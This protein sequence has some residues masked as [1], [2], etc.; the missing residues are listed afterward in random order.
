MEEWKEGESTPLKYLIL[1]QVGIHCPTSPLVTTHNVK[2]SIIITCG[3]NFQKGTLSFKIILS[4]AHH[5]SFCHFVQEVNE[6]WY[7]G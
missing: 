6:I 4:I 7:P 2:D 3:P 5:S 1:L